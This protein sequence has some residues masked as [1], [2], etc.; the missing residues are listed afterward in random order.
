MITEKSQLF[1]VYVGFVP[2]VCGFA[3]LVAWFARDSR[4]QLIYKY[5]ELI[6]PTCLVALGFL[7]RPNF[8]P[9]NKRPWTWV[10]PDGKWWEYLIFGVTGSSF[11]MVTLS[12]T[13]GAVIVVPI[14]LPF[15]LL[16][17]YVFGSH[18][19]LTSAVVS[20]PLVSAAVGLLFAL[21]YGFLVIN[22]RGNFLE[23][24]Q[25]V[26]EPARGRGFT[27]TDLCQFSL[28]IMFDVDS[29]WEPVGWCKWMVLAQAAVTKLLEIAVVGIGV[30]L[31]I[32]RLK[33]GSG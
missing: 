1:W 23:S 20:V 15:K 8:P 24:G 19:S 33:P 31:I 30:A 11:A 32:E 29:S 18:A 14:L 13:A 22:D 4:Y 9:D 25:P 12:V 27:A 7:G 3:T 17:V 21:L 10:P 16:T 28:S 6:G 5:A 2:A 26:Y